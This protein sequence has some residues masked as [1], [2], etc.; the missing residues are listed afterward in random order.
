MDT[1]PSP[2]PLRSFA[3]T[4]A[5]LAACLLAP[6]AF[7]QSSTQGEQVLRTSFPSR[8]VNPLTLTDPATGPA[9]SC[10]D[11]AIL[12]QRVSF[13]DVWYLY[14][15]GDPLN[16]NDKNGS[17]GLKNHLITQYRS[18]D[19]AHWTYIGD[20]FSTLPAWIGGVTDQLW[21]PAVEHFNNKYYLYYAAPNSVT[22]TF[23]YKFL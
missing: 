23:N 15:T 10:P 5:M 17:G 21:A 9:V 19:L 11:P 16:S 3:W 13:Y 20:V 7:A 8:Y 1:T 4:L 18:Y 12:K 22:L 14:C 6:S 2:S